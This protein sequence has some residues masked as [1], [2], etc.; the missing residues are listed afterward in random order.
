MGRRW[1]SS[2]MLFGLVLVGCASTQ[3]MTSES[4]GTLALNSPSVGLSNAMRE[5]WTDHVVWPN[6]T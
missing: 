1:S 2:A 3:T 6:R 4:A 5:L